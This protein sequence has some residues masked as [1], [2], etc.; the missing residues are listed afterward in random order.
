VFTGIVE[1][2]GE[3]VR[4]TPE[5]GNVRLTIRCPFAGELK[6]DQSVAHNGACLTVDQ[7]GDGVYEVVCIPETLRRTNLGALRPGDSV[8]LERSVRAGDRLDGHI[9]QGHVDATGIIRRITPAGGS[10]E[11]EIDYNGN[12][13]E[14]TVEKGSVC[15]NGVSLTV[16]ESRP[17][18]FR[19]DLIP[20][21][22]AHTTFRTAREGDSVNIEFDILGK[23]I[24][25]LVAG[26]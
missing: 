11:V 24:R 7:A 23:Y 1:T 10:W 25:K 3:I 2:T 15:V 5:S 22:H 19:V 13:D 6:P 4:V 8:N 17:Q 26:G 20:Y 21:T 16:V 14:I 12:S 18:A 9:V